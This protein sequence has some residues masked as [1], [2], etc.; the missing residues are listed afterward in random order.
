MSVALV[1]HATAR[2]TVLTGHL[3]VGRLIS[4]RRQLRPDTAGVGGRL[5]TLG[6]RRVGSVDLVGLSSLSGSGALA[7]LSGLALS[8][9][10]LLASLPLLPNFLEF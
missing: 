5:S 8:L 6:I 9:F 10:L 7:L 3:A 4:N 1:D 2:G